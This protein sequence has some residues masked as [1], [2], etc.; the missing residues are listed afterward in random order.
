MERYRE[1][2]KD[3]GCVGA[4]DRTLPSFCM[5]CLLNKTKLLQPVKQ[6]LNAFTLVLF[7][8]LFLL[9]ETFTLTTQPLP[10]VSVSRPFLPFYLSQMTS[11]ALL[12]LDK[13]CVS[14]AAVKLSLGSKEAESLCSSSVHLQ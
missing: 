10:L 9:P 11:L 12:P 3:K 7:C 6:T 2:C 13:N 4:W 14:F 8:C 5:L 1:R